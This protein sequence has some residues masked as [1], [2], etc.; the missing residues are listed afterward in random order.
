M[1]SNSCSVIDMLGRVEYEDNRILASLPT[2]YQTLFPW[3]NQHKVATSRLLNARR[4]TR[5][6]TDTHS[7][8]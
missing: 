7:S 2:L 5:K 3:V 8:S 4:G 1:V 6:W